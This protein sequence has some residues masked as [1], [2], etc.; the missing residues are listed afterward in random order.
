MILATHGSGEIDQFQSGDFNQRFLHG[1]LLQ[2]AATALGTRASNPLKKMQ[3]LMVIACKL[4]RII[5][6]ILKTDVRFDA[7]K[8][9]RDIVRPSQ[10]EAAA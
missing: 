2:W 9:M 1:I 10:Q 5:F 7:E 8:M 6:T 4:L 3:S